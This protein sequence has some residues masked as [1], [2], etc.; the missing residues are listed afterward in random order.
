MDAVL[1]LDQAYRPLRV[2]H[3]KKAI[4][5]VFLGKAETVEY[6]KDRTIQGIA[7]VYPMP[8]VVRVVRAFKR[9]RIAIKF[10]RLNVYMRD[11]FTCQYCVQRLMAEELTFDHVVPK[12][13]GGKTVW[14]NVV[15]CCVPCNKLKSDRS[16]DAAG[17]WPKKKPIK[18]RYL[19]A[20]TVRGMD[21]RNIPAEWRAY[22]NTA[23]E[24]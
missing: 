2:D 21:R 4:V 18:P 12:S 23:L 16:T 5:D 22:W 13:K 14:E 8:S 17:M 3:W 11:D 7:R 19:P 15:A 6:S 10:S 9:D 24:S 1:V 20:V